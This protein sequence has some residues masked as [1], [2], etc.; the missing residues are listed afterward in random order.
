MKLKQFEQHCGYVFSLTFANGKYIEADLAPLIADH[1]DTTELGSARID[2]DWGC[3][4][5]KN[6]TVDIEPNTLYQWA[7]SHN[8]QHH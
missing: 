4:E 1:V 5:F 8:L 2:Q 3:L 6:G 7:E